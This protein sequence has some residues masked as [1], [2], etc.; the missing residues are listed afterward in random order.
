M[1]ALSLSR[2]DHKG[3]GRD[4]IKDKDG[5]KI[6]NSLNRI[7][8]QGMKELDAKVSQK[9]LVTDANP[10]TN[11]M[12]GNL[13]DKSPKSGNVFPGKPSKNAKIDGMITLIASISILMDD[14]LMIKPKRKLSADSFLIM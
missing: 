6:N 10:V 1:N 14:K 7:M 2:I 5:N 12:A 11:W 4:E 8:N 3:F 13:I 9:S